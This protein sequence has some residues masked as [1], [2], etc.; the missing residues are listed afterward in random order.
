MTFE[1]LGSLTFSI[2]GDLT[3]KR[4]ATLDVAA[5]KEPSGE[6]ERVSWLRATDQPR[7]VDAS[8]LSENLEENWSVKAQGEER[9][10]QDR[11]LRKI[12][13]QLGCAKLI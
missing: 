12:R 7:R 9:L 6:I 11:L 13:R 8:L 2:L 5:V 1:T 3:M 10:R 4:A